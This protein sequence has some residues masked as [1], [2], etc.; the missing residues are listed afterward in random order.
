MKEYALLL[1]QYL[2]L[3]IKGVLYEKQKIKRVFGYNKKSKFGL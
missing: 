1:Y 3:K 2:R